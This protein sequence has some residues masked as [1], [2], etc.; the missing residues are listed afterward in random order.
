MIKVVKCKLIPTAEQRESILKTLEYFSVGCNLAL[1]KALQ[2]KTYRAYPLYYLCY[3]EIKKITGLNA[4]YVCTAINKVARS[5]G[6][7]KRPPKGFKPTSLDLKKSLVR[8][9][10]ITETVSLSSMDGRLNGIKVSIG[11]Y[12]RKLL[13]GQKPKAGVLSYDKKKNRFYICFCIEIETPEPKGSNPLGVDRGIN[14]IVTTSDGFIKSGKNLNQLREKVQRTRGSLQRKKAEGTKHGKRNNAW[15]VLKRLSGKMERIM[16]DTNHILSKQITERAKQT[17]SFIVFENLEGINK[18]CKNKGKRLR[19]ILGGWAFY[20]LQTF[21]EYKAA[22]AGVPVVYIDPRNTSK[23]CS[24]CF[25][26]GSRKKHKFSCSCGNVMDADFNASKNIAR[27]GL[28][29]I[30]PEVTC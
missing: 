19:K 30:K 3:Y 5:F 1:E 29:A 9:N 28:S 15:R 2:N 10:Q 22:Q 14:R 26:I 7:G 6:K 12:Q 8:Y 20:Q 17:N 16:K 21:T 4:D 27:L 23:T 11:E 18:R 24:V 13:E 25:K